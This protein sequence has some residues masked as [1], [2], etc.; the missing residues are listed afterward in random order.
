MTIDIDLI[1]S[2]GK[3]VQDLGVQVAQHF[4]DTMF[5]HYPEVRKMFPGDMSEQRVRLFN[6]VILIASNI[7]NTD[8]LVPYL[9]ELGVGHIRYDTRPEHYPIVGKSLLRPLQSPQKPLPQPWWMATP[10]SR[11][12]STMH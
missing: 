3:A 9:K 4:Y 12:A 6:S 5:S 11:A 8:M 2:S 7:D 10:C 1:K